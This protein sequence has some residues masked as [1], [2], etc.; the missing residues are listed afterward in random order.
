M[1]VHDLRDVGCNVSKFSSLKN[2]ETFESLSSDSTQF[3]NHRIYMKVSYDLAFDLSS[4]ELICMDDETERVILLDSEI[5][6]SDHAN[7]G[8][9]C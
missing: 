1:L 2:G 8:I 4:K 5:F 6:I 9:G 3:V 7:S